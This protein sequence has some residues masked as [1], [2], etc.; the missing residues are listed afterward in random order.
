[1][2]GG[3]RELLQMLIPADDPFYDLPADVILTPTDLIWSNRRAYSHGRFDPGAA[4][5]DS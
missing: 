4:P 2:H 3:D 5:E 1:M